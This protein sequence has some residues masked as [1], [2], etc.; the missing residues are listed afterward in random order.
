MSNKLGL[1]QDPAK[2]EHEIK[3]PL[4]KPLYHIINPIMAVLLRSPLH[5]L[6][7]KSLMLLS[8]KGRKS[9]K[10]YT[11]PVG[12]MQAGEDLFVFTHTRWWKNLIGGAPVVLRLR[13]RDV[14]G[15]ATPIADPIRIAEIAQM[16]VARHGTAMA[17]RMGLI[18]A[19]DDAAPAPRGTTFIE[20]KLGE[21]SA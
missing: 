9:G 2:V 6:L 11:V 14:S 21:H 19:G 4:P 13:G 20:I 8:F 7:S 18:G 1:Q 10:R 12:Y 17:Q 16:F 15:T 5:G 3:P